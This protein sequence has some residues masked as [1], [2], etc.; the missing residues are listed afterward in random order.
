MA[1]SIA[2][3]VNAMTQQAQQDICQLRDF[4]RVPNLTIKLHHVTN[5]LLHAELLRLDMLRSV[6][7]ELQ[8][9]SA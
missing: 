7:A 5:N 4:A 2:E 3:F 8:D 9:P 6:I 1:R